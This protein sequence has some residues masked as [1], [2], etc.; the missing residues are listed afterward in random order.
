MRFR[1]IVTPTKP[2]FEITYDSRILL[3]GSCFADHMAEKLSRNKFHILSNPFGVLYN[4]ASIFQSMMQIKDSQVFNE[5]DLFPFQNQ[6][7]SFAHHSRFS[8]EN[9][10]EVLKQIN[11]Q[12]KTAHQ[13]ITGAHILII[14]FGTA[15]VYYEKTGNKL[16]AN[17]HK[18]PHNRFE[19]KLLPTESIIKGFEETLQEIRKLNPDIK[20]ILTVSPIR[21]LKDGAGMNNRSKARLIEAVHHIVETTK[22]VYYF[23]A[24]EIVMDE[25]RDYRFYEENMTH[26]NQ[27]AISYVW[28]KFASALIPPNVQAEMKKI[29]K[30]IKAFEHRI[31]SPYSEASKTFAKNQLASISTI[32]AKNPGLDF[33]AE[34]VYFES[35]LMKTPA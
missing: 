20:V 32:L 6:W 15:W 25:L 2:P 27:L 24:Y 22:D 12:I 5:R 3:T 14:T 35:L 30:V 33:K 29:E 13:Q 31:T 21:H 16:V 26:P 34:T 7:H 10:D 18:M 23:P 8:N 28:E 9:K 11:A 1:T 19:K 4:P 17:C